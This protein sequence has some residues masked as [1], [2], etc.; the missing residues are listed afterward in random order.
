MFAVVLQAAVDR[1]ESI[2]EGGM[3]CM[4]RIAEPEPGELRE[5][6]KTEV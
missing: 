6:S 1:T 4:F 3:R 5:M 2:V